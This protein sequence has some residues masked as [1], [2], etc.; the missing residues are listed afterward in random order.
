MVLPTLC[1]GVLFARFARYFG[2]DAYRANING[3][4]G[5]IISYSAA[6]FMAVDRLAFN[7]I[8]QGISCRIRFVF[9][10]RLRSVIF[11]VKLFVQPMGQY[12]VCSIYVRRDYNSNDYVSLVSFFYRR[13]TY[14]RRVCFKFNNA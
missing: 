11:Y 12:N 9:N 8:F 13:A 5:V 7:V 14:F 1:L 10:G 2:R 3:R 6:G 4:E